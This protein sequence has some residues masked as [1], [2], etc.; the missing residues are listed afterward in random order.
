MWETREKSVNALN[1][2]LRA[3]LS[4]V[5]GSIEIIEE[6]VSL[7]SSIKKLTEYSRVCCLITIKALNL[8]QRIL[9]LS[10]DGLAQEACALLHPTKECIELLIP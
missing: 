8:V 10:L 2:T 1:K 6:L 5:F 4:L 7:F 3:E 9:N